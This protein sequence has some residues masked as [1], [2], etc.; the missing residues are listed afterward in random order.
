MTVEG[1]FWQVEVKET[2]FKRDR[3]EFMLYKKMCMTIN[4][5]I[6]SIPFSVTLAI[7]Q[8]KLEDSNLF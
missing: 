2:A 3:R 5:S 7:F 8:Q 1:K 6:E 4:I